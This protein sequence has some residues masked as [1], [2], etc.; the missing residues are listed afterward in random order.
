MTHRLCS[1]SLLT[2]GAGHTHRHGLAL[3]RWKVLV[4]WERFISFCPVHSGLDMACI[5]NMLPAL[6]FI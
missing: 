5:Y 4:V 6:P 1:T 3:G 2:T